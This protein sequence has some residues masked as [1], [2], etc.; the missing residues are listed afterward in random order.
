MLWEKLRALV[1]TRDDQSGSVTPFVLIVTIALFMLAGLVIDGGRQMN[2]KSR[3]FA[4][5]QEASRAGAQTIDLTR[6]AAV[7]DTNQ[8]VRA[9]E[10]FCGDAMAR[11]EDLV[12]CEAS[13]ED[14]ANETG[15]VVSVQVNTTVETDAIL[16]GMFGMDVWTAN[17]EARARPVQGV[18]DPQS[19]QELTMAPPETG[20]PKGNPFPTGSGP[21]PTAAPTKKCES[22]YY[23]PYDITNTWSKGDPPRKPPITE[24]EPTEPVPCW[25]AWD[26]PKKKPD[27]GGGNNDGGGGNGN[28]NQNG[29]NGN[30]GGNNAENENKGRPR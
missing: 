20:G 17:G 25:P 7:L 12:E 22:P 6:D 1:P 9:A 11:D 24:S 27:D 18:V 21:P 15:D 2:S 14:T 30:N 8:A 23:D 28:G 4:Y 16:S 13:V 26:P 5:A 19:G 3:A 10:R 29:N